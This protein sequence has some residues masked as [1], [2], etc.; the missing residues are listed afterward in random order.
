MKYLPLFLIPIFLLSSCGTETIQTT[1]YYKTYKTE[2]G[3]ITMKDDIIS[4]VEW[5]KTSSLAFRSPGIIS[6]ISV[7]PGDRVKKWQVLARLGNNESTIQAN[8]LNS[9]QQGLQSLQSSTDTIRSG[10]EN[11]SNANSKL[12]DE[13][14]KGVDTS[15]LSLQNT[16][17]QAKQNLNNQTSSLG[18]TFETFAH[19][20]D[21]VATSMLYEGDKILGITTNFEY[22][23]D[24]WE[25]YLGTRVGD[26]RALATNEW[27][28]VYTLR[29]KIRV[30][31]ETGA[32]IADINTARED[33]SNAYLG[34]R[35]F[36]K[37]MNYMLQN[38]VVGG[39]LS[40]EQLNGWNGIWTRLGGDNQGSE[41]AF[42]A[43]KN[44]T[45]D[46]TS[47]TNGSG[48]VAAEKNI[49]ALQLELNNLRQ[50][51]NTLL[52]EKQAKLKEIKSSA[53]TV[54]SKKGEI[55]VQYK[56][57]QMNEA[58]AQE[59]L[60][61]S[62]IYAPYDGV[63]LEKSMEVGMVIGAGSPLLKISSTDG[64]MVKTYIDND[65][66]QYNTS[67][68]IYSIGWPES[69]TY[70]GTISLIQEQKDPLH[71]KNY[72]E[73]KM[74]GAL[75]IGEK[76]T[77]HLERKK[78]NFQNGIIVPLSSIINRYGPPGVYILE[79]QTARFQLVKILNSDM[80]FAEIIGIPEWS[81]IITDGKENIYDG[82]KLTPQQ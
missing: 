81:T 67:A 41:A 82:E 32:T 14:I 17:A 18:V 5:N 28:K 36:A 16:I 68:E 50:A 3:T 78:T 48:S 37:A 65:I 72:T 79:D 80:Q 42:V 75:A 29:W 51:K 22:A 74:E 25:P 43:W 2:I 13:R 61:Y 40:E 70:T 30:Y 77:L 59:A 49:T 38:S 73:I 7:R 62:I 52:A 8:G 4:T 76:V 6:N 53:D 39:G 46:L 33:L 23:N 24:G 47:T 71:N 64:K 15:I 19:D 9:I 66:Y 11:M 20:F 35:G 26:S 56:E 10:I 21:R 45:L 60:E 44:N 27:N 55:L 57:S 12:Y 54:N 34:T 69:S 58:L 31:T 1:K 63:I